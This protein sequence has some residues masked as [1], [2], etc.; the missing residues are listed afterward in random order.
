MSILEATVQLVPE[1]KATSP[2]FFRK[3]QY[4]STL[5]DLAE[6]VP[7]TQIEIAPEVYQ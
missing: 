3:I 6:H 4:I 5:S 7:I 1:A 2:K